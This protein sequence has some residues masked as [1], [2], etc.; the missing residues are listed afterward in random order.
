M[1][2]GGQA[3]ALVF[4]GG[5]QSGV[6]VFEPTIGQPQPGECRGRRR[7]C[8]LRVANDRIDHQGEKQPGERN[9]RRHTEP[10][11]EA[12]GIGAGREELDSAIRDQPADEE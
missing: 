2:L 3:D 9:G 11:T 1:K 6:Q 8:S 5:F 12:Q 7:C 4:L 10:V